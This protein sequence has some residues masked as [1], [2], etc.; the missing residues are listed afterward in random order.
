MNRLIARFATLG[1]LGLMLAACGGNDAELQKYAKSKSMSES[2]TAAFMAC[3]N[4]HRRTKP[5]FPAPDGSV[6]MK[7]VPPEVCGCQTKIITAVFNDKQYGGYVSFADYM[8]KD[9][10]KRHLPRF[11]RKDLQKGIKSPD[12]AK[13]LEGGL[14]ACVDSYKSGHKEEAAAIFEFIPKPPEAPKDKK[15]ASAS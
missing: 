8:G 2:Q 5:L 13:R 11:L 3:A 7:S 14:S 10:K 1:G 6:V 12:A 4:G 15:A 9:V